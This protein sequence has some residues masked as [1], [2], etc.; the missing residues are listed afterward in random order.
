MKTKT[1]IGLLIAALSLAGMAAWE[2]SL[3]ERFTTVEVLAAAADIPK[4]SEISP[5]MLK[6]V[7]IGADSE[8]SGAL[9]YAAAAQISG[10]KALIDICE[11]EPLLSSFFG[12]KNS[13]LDGGLSIYS[14][15]A[16]WIY[17]RP[18]GLRAGDRVAVYALP[19][20]EKLGSY[21]IAFV[22][23]SGEL[24][25][26]GDEKDSSDMLSRNSAG[27][28]ISS[29]EI[30][31]RAEDYFAIYDRSLGGAYP[32]VFEDEGDMYEAN[33]DSMSPEASQSG[34]SDGWYYRDERDEEPKPFILLVPEV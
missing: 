21:E 27:G 15:P 22:R 26:L 7:R 4:G 13:V 1:I 10:K 31:C 12:E 34:A 29:V 6:T 30:I 19:E 9:G 2:L 16:S 32:M 11:G 23:D 18:A 14:L 5:D 28:V 25:V 8:P 33:E 3:R 20:K 24:A 17:S